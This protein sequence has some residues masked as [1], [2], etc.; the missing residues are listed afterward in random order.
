MNW[1]AYFIAMVVKILNGRTLELGEKRK[2]RKSIR[3]G[4]RPKE[5]LEEG[6]N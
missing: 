6:K 3:Q 4:P 2:N 1:G 5:Y